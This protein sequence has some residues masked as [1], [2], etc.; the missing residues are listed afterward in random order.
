VVGDLVTVQIPS[1]PTLTFKVAS[2]QTDEDQLAF[3]L[4]SG[5]DGATGTIVENNIIDVFDGDT[6]YLFYQTDGPNA[7]FDYST[8]HNNDAVADVQS[9]TFHVQVGIIY[10]SWYAGG[11]SGAFDDNVTNAF[12][13]MGLTTVTSTNLRLIQATLANYQMYWPN[14]N[15][16]T[17]YTSG[18]NRAN[19]ITAHTP[20]S[21]CLKDP[22]GPGSTVCPGKNTDG[23]YST[24]LFPADN[25]GVVSWT[26]YGMIFNPAATH[27]AAM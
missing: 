19:A 5:T 23:T 3:F 13:T 16:T 2:I 24:A 20:S 15:Q 11:G 27:T 14:Y 21:L 26:V 4:D 10:E 17:A 25:A 18:Y 22:G 1:G 12:G 7:G 6:I 9:T 8:V